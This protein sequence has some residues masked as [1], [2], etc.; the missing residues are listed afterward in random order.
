MILFG[1]I[2][3]EVYFDMAVRLMIIILSFVVVV[4]LILII[5]GSIMNINIYEKYGKQIFKSFALF[6]IAVIAVY[7]ALS[8]FALH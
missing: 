1:K 8:L 7:V 3:K 4:N 2:L 6:F 5:I